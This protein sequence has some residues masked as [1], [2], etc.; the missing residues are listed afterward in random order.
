MLLLFFKFITTKFY[1]FSYIFFFYIRAKIYLINF[2]CCR[3]SLGGRPQVLHRNGGAA[4][5][6]QLPPHLAAGNHQQQQR[7]LLHCSHSSP[8]ANNN[9]INITAGATPI[10]GGS[11]S[12][13]VKL[14]TINYT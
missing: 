8:I 6:H 3:C 5:A 10:L 1:F 7:G 2:Y 12:P 14:E 11:S 4:A 9:N 13:M